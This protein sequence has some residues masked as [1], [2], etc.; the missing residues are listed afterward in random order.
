MD[1]DDHLPEHW[2][3]TLLSS[4]DIFFC[5]FTVVNLPK[6]GSMSHKRKDYGYTPPQAP[7][8]TIEKGLTPPSAPTK[9][10]K[11]EEG[12]TPPQRPIAPPAPPPA[13]PQHRRKRSSLRI[14]K[15]SK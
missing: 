5:Y 1:E 11:I 9:P 10:K 15:T 8:K 7:V 4:G 13:A 2:F 12:Y 14:L 3:H 6:E